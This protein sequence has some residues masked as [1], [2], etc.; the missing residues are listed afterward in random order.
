M[1]YALAVKTPSIRKQSIDETQHIDHKISPDLNSIQSDIKFKENH[2]Y[3]RNEK[4]D[5]TSDFPSILFVY[6]YPETQKSDTSEYGGENVIH[7]ANYKEVAVDGFGHNQLKN[8]SSY[9]LEICQDKDFDIK[10]GYTYSFKNESKIERFDLYTI[11]H[12]M[13]FNNAISDLIEYD[14]KS[15][16][17]PTDSNTELSL[18]KV[19]NSF[20][21]SIKEVSKQFQFDELVFKIIEQT[22]KY[23]KSAKAIEEYLER[24]VS[25]S[26]DDEQRNLLR[27][28][29]K[30][31]TEKLQIN[32]FQS[33]LI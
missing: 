25:R 10:G 29:F 20:K 31:I 26:D 2:S 30:I 7:I 23:V 12:A 6:L 4:S 15:I 33:S 1:N 17:I 18:I 21:V 5:V 22:Q 8:F 14:K 3:E 28:K 13:S 27:E 19:G 24:D 11:S 32:N 16:S 9:L